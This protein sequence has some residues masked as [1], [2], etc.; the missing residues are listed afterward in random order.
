MV[1]SQEGGEE[2]EEEYN[3]TAEHPGVP[4]M[5]QRFK[6]LTSIHEDAGSRPCSEG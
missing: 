4:V 1:Q 3:F 2:E 5:T 6:N